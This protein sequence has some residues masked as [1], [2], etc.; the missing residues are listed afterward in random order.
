M[1]LVQRAPVSET[2]SILYPNG[3][4]EFWLTDRI[5]APGDV[6]KRKKRSWVVVRNDRRRNNTVVVMPGHVDRP[7]AE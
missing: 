2:V 7:E 3:E 4:R 6:F 5:F 1:S